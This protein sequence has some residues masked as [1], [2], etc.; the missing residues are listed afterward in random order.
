MRDI[1]VFEMAKFLATE[2]NT[3]FKGKLLQGIRWFSDS[4]TQSEPENKLLA[5]TISLESLLPSPKRIGA[6]GAWM[7]EGAT[8]LLGTDLDERNRIRGNTL[9]LYGERNAVM[10]EGESEEIAMEDVAWLRKVVH[11]L[12]RTVIDR[13]EEFED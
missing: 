8:I 2:E 10:H 9:G 5:L 4:Q 12:I 13:R 11:S 6:T 3:E 1:G 7:A